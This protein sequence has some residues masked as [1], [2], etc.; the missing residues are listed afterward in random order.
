MIQISGP[1]E[2]DAPIT[3]AVEWV[4]ANSGATI[5]DNMTLRLMCGPPICPPV[6]QVPP[7]QPGQTAEI[8]F[9]HANVLEPTQLVYAMVGSNNAVFGELLH[10]LIAPQMAVAAPAGVVLISPMDFVKAPIQVQ[11]H[12]VVAPEFTLANVGEV[13]W[14]EDASIVLFFNTPGFENLPTSIDVPKG[15]QPGQTAVVSIAMVIPETERR[16]LT[17][18]WALQSA[19]IPDFGDVVTLTFDVDDFPVL[20]PQPFEF[21]TPE[22]EEVPAV[23]EVK[24]A[25]PGPLKNDM[26]VL[27]HEHHPQKEVEG[28]ASE[29]EN[30]IHSLGLVKG[31]ASG[32]PWAVQLV[33]RNSGT[34]PWPK[35]CTLKHVFGESLGV[36]HLEM[37]GEPICPGEA[38]EVVMELVCDKMT[39][40]CDAAWVLTD[41]ATN[42]V[43]GP[44]IH[45]AIA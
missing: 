7:A 33:L 26:Q 14:P 31:A 37:E 21:V 24:S 28:A 15:V 40:P 6:V 45:I 23:P 25:Q 2:G 32:E 5:W 38:V 41:P 8:F 4:L 10:V 43:L 44:V 11:H 3:G 18:M 20:P 12:D 30:G 22:K 42:I 13:P 17:A 29:P 19:S 35:N 9:D 39:A 34:E 1:K 36:T 16:E 27:Y